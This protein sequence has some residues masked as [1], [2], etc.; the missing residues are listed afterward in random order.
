M[1]VYEMFFRGIRKAVA[2]DK[3]EEFAH[4]FLFMYCSDKGGK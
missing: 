1:H 3:L 4:S 2:T